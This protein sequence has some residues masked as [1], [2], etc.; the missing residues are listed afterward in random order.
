MEGTVEGGGKKKVRRHR[1]IEKLEGSAVQ[2]AIL[3]YD[4]RVIKRT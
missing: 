4:V 2:R 3:I 1:G